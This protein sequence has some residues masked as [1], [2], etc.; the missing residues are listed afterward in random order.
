M[1]PEAPAR[2]AS[3]MPCVHRSSPPPGRETRGSAQG[4]IRRHCRAEGDGGHGVMRKQKMLMRRRRRRKREDEKLVWAGQALRQMGFGV[5][6]TESHAESRKERTSAA[7]LEV[8]QAFLCTKRTAGK[9]VKVR[10][11]PKHTHPTLLSS[12][13]CTRIRGGGGAEA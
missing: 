3:E 8:P 11:L 7:N 4:W 1:Y 5:M 2:T 6:K 9:R 13:R 10:P 12:R